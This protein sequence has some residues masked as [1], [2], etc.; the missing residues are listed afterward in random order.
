MLWNRLTG[1]GIGVAVMD[2][3]ARVPFVSWLGAGEIVAFWLFFVL[4]CV[5]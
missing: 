4:Y 5:Y 3:G 2:T 1:K